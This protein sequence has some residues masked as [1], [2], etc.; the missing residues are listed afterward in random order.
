MRLQDSRIAHFGSL[1]TRRLGFR[2]VVF[3]TIELLLG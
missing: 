1:A 2:I 3:D